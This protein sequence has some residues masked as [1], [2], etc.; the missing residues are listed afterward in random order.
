ML[1]SKYIYVSC[2]KYIQRNVPNTKIY[3]YI[4]TYRSQKYIQN[5]PQKYII[6]K[7]YKEIY[8]Y[9]HKIIQ[10]CIDYTKLYQLHK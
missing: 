1:T 8:T 9:I 3:I 7:L 4:Y 6:H 5:T 2:V 10:R